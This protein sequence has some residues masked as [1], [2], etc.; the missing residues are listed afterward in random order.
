MPLKTGKFVKSYMLN[1]QAAIRGYEGWNGLPETVGVWHLCKCWKTLKT[2]TEITETFE[3][4]NHQASKAGQRIY[5][6]K[7]TLHQEVWKH[8]QEHQWL[9]S[10]SSSETSKIGEDLDFKEQV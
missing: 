1:I 7:L 4:Y 3:D 8:V 10:L 5:E 6:K 9:N 2:Y